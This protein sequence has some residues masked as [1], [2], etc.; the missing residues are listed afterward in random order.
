MNCRG[1]QLSPGH[2]PSLIVPQDSDCL[3]SLPYLRSHIHKSSSEPTTFLFSPCKPGLCDQCC[4]DICGPRPPPLER[5]GK[6][7]NPLCSASNFYFLAAKNIFKM[8]TRYCVHILCVV[9]K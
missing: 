2:W 8:K 3:V 6:L 9:L 4:Q 7:G 5:E 1:T